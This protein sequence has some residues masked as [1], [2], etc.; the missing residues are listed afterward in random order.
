MNTANNNITWM[1]VNLS[2]VQNNVNY[3]LKNVGVPLMAIVKADAYGC[4]AIE[5]GKCALDAGAS[6]LGVAR[7]SEAHALR[8]KLQCPILVLG[9][10]SP[11]EVDLAIQENVTL[12]LYDFEIAKMYAQRASIC[13]RKLSV[14]LKIDTGM[15]RLGV[16]YQDAQALAKFALEQEYLNIDGIY[17]HLAMAEDTLNH[18]FSA[19][20]LNRFNKAIQS[21]NDIGIFPKWIHC[22]NSGASI[23]MPEAR[24]NL[25]RTGAG[26]VSIKPVDWGPFPPELRRVISW[27][28]RLVSSK[29]IPAGWGIG[30]GQEYK[31]QKDEN[32]G[33]LAV[34]YA[35]GFHNLPGNEV[36]INEKRISIVGRVCCDMCMVRLPERF[37][38]GTEVVLLGNQGDESI[39][40]EDLASRWKLSDADITSLINQRVPRVYIR[41]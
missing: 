9:L 22:S 15:G 31:L 24:F 38:I 2:A 20:Q 37:P 33:V 35:D 7:Y 13:K 19:E 32:I 10:V 6:W 25:V 1:E 16:F 4:G 8:S 12:T 17:S 30:Y 27:K 14:H 36:L 28:T 26:L 5:I 40:I 23:Y 41:D 11:E 39:T 29:V 18:P 3:Y 34:G 21:L